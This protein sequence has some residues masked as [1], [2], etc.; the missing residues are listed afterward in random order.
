MDCLTGHGVLQ[1]NVGLQANTI[2]SGQILFAPDKELGCRTLG[3]V[4]D[5]R[6]LGKYRGALDKHRD[7]NNQLARALAGNRYGHWSGKC[8][9]CRIPSRAPTLVREN[10][11]AGM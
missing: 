4:Q 11:V 3:K 1:A 2:S 9:K 8:Q 6:A 5:Y 10:I 7:L